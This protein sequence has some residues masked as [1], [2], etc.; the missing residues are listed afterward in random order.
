M[1]EMY[2]D[3]K[4]KLVFRVEAGDDTSRSLGCTLPR[5]KVDAVIV[6]A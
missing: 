4:P 6:K 2:K 1:F 5:R 3:F